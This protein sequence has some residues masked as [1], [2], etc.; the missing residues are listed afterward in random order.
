MCL[1]ENLVA[2]SK[3]AWIAR[4][5]KPLALAAEVRPLPTDP[6]PPAILHLAWP[7]RNHSPQ[8]AQVHHPVREARLEVAVEAAAVHLPALVAL[9][10]G[11][12]PVDSVARSRRCQTSKS[13]I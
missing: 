3:N 13:P 11:V 10:P 8:P 1:Q 2:R 7:F 4:P 6:V 5:R 12:C 9:R